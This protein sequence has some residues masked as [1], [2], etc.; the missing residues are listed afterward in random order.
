[1]PIQ[2]PTRVK[3]LISL[4]ALCLL[5]STS[6]SVRADSGS[7]GALAG[8]ERILTE[9]E[10]KRRLKIIRALGD[11]M[12]GVMDL[13]SKDFVARSKK[14]VRKF[15]ENFDK[16]PDVTD[17]KILIFLNENGKYMFCDLPH[18]WEEHYMVYARNNNY[19]NKLFGDFLDGLSTTIAPNVNFIVRRNPGE[20]P[21]TYLDTLLKE[22]GNMTYSQ[23]V[24]DSYQSLATAAKQMYGAKTW[25]ELS[26]TSQ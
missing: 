11:R 10:N 16:T 21:E 15:M 18:G 25:K 7:D 6:L 13:D 14:M 24:R 8:S 19:H 3:Q 2:S 20:N 1:M 23:G 12:C 9:V 17:D 26:A 22:A 4:I 5:L